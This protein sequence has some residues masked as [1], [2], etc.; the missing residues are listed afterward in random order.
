[1]NDHLLFAASVRPDSAAVRIGHVDA[2]V[3][4]ISVSP[5]EVGQH[6]IAVTLA[7]IPLRGVPFVFVA[8][9]PSL[10]SSLRGSLEVMWW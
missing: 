2:D 4:Q 3:Y 8:V 7:G 5:S 6:A 9:P 1:M 10:R